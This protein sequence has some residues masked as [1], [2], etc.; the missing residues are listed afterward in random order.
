MHIFADVQCELRRRDGDKDKR[1]S[2]AFGV[3]RL[4][5]RRLRFKL[6]VVGHVPRLPSGRRRRTTSFWGDVSM[7]LQD[8][9]DKWVAVIV[10]ILMGWLAFFGG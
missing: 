6:D 8:V 3:G 4:T 7:V 5:A 1:G 9:I 10:A 2:G